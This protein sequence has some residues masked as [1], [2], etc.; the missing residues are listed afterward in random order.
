MSDDISQKHVFNFVI[1]GEPVEDL[2]V[3]GARRWFVVYRMV[4]GGPARL[5]QR[6]SLPEARSDIH[7]LSHDPTVLNAGIWEQVCVETWRRPGT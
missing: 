5:I 3:I 7:R 1:A 4:K 2:A 6:L